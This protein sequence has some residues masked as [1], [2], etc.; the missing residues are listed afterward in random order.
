MAELRHF[1]QFS[2]FLKGK[3]ILMAAAVCFVHGHGPG[4]AQLVDKQLQEIKQ[5]MFRMQASYEH[6]L[7]IQSKEISQLKSKVITGD[8]EERVAKL[9]DLGK[10]DTLRL[11]LV[12]SAVFQLF[13]FSLACKSFF[14]KLN[15]TC[16][17]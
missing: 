3:L 17:Y 2:M 1:L 13:Y 14:V 6:Q 16:A 7:A 12:H 8:L 4:G 9:E 15:V 5:E 10:I 11:Y